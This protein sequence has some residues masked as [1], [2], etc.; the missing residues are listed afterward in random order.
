MSRP[1]ERNTVDE[2]EYSG[3]NEVEIFDRRTVVMLP[4]QGVGFYSKPV[5]DL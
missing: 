2:L 3:E 1:D 5:V 4:A